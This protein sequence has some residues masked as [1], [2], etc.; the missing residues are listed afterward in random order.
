MKIQILT[1]FILSSFNIQSQDLLSLLD[2]DKEDRIV[3]SIFKDSRIINAQSSKLSSKGELKFLIQHRFGTINQGIYSLYGIDDA[4]VRFGFEYGLHDNVTLSF[5]RS[6][7]LK[8]YD[9]GAKIN[10]L[11]QTNKTPISV[12]SYSAFFLIH[13]SDFFRERPDFL[14]ANYQSF[15]NQLIISRKFSSKL[16]L[17]LLPTHLYLV[18]RTPVGT[19]YL[20]LGGRYKLSKRVSLNGEYFYNFRDEFNAL[21]YVALGF[22][23]ETGGHVFSLHLSNSR[24]MNEHAF[25][26]ETMDWTQGNI[27]F[28]FNISRV[29]K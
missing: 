10:Y 25:L 4:K 9:L 3:Q 18:N 28:G 6:S 21:Q 7:S 17:A 1:I 16:S 14:W 8:Q 20:G 11:K 23:I 22:D 29:F 12:S 13:P 19:M 26:T 2:S 5:G 24:G 15:S 27:Y